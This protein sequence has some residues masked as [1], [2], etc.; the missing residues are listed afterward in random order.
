MALIAKE[1]KIEKI[2]L[3]IKMDQNLKSEIDAYCRW[4]GIE[5]LNHFFSEAIK[6]LLSK[7][8]A[9]VKHNLIARENKM[10]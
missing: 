6:V 1:Q 2:A 4:A 5:D 3:R 9:W 7:D 8:K 10:F